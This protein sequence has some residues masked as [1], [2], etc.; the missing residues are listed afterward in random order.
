MERYAERTKSHGSGV[1]GYEMSQYKHFGCTQFRNGNMNVRIER[2]DLEDFKKDQVFF[3]S[4]L[5]WWMNCDF[6]GETY[7]LNNFETG[8]TIYNSYMNCTYIFAWSDLDK[9]A[10]GKTV[11][12][13][14]RPV[15]EE[16]RE[17]I[18]RES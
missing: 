6:I 8:H 1:T 17:L 2:E 12:L 16:D 7:C 14:A 5:L 18:E 4:D 9:L 10:K 3:L 15:S 13:Y 11:K